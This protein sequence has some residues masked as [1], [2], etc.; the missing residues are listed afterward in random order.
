[1]IYSILASILVI[2]ALTLFFNLTPEQVTD[3]ILQI[4][5]PKDSMRERAKNLRQNR[6]KHKLYS[7]LMK[8]KTALASTGKS[9]QFTFVCFASIF[10]FGA[11]IIFSILIDNLYLAPVVAVAFG[12][13]PFIYSSNTISTYEKHL[14][15]EMETTLSII[16]NSYLRSDNIISSVE[17][18]LE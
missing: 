5:T 6:K 15:Q 11:G 7:V 4:I 18:N 12:L 9:K 8:F 16:T 13:V 17:E 10:L 1:M 2:T 3:D 14:K